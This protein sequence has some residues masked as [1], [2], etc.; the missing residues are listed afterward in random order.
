MA[1]F[2]GPGNWAGAGPRHT[3]ILLLPT[4]QRAECTVPPFPENVHSYQMLADEDGVHACG[5]RVGSGSGRWSSECFSLLFNRK[6]WFR[7]PDVPSMNTKRLGANGLT[8]GKNKEWWMIGGHD[9]NGLITSIEIRGSDGVWAN[10]STELPSILNN[11]CIVSINENQFLVMGG[12]NDMGILASVY[13][14]DQSTNVWER[15]QDMAGARQEHACTFK[16]EEKKV[17]VAGGQGTNSELLSSSEIY[18]ISQNSWETGPNLPIATRGAKMITV[19]NE[20]YHIGGQETRTEIYRLSKDKSSARSFIKVGN[21]SEGKFWFDVVAIK[22][23]PEN[24][25]GWK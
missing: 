16:E 12:K 24:C 2:I 4:L 20:V 22:I 15:K 25:N 5:G 23:S 11:P 21:L 14:Y 9:G 8:L 17:I 18:D 10:S 3:E 19:D 1:L 7:A 6:D 13:L